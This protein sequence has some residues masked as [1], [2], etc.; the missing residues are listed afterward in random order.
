MSK[1]N[2]LIMI[3]LAVLVGF[4]AYPYF[5]PPTAPSAEIVKV[6]TSK[7]DHDKSLDDNSEAD[8]DIEDRTQSTEHNKPENSLSETDETQDSNTD[9]ASDESG[10]PNVPSAATSGNKKDFSSYKLHDEKKTYA[11]SESDPRIRYLNGKY[12]GAVHGYSVVLEINQAIS[13]LNFSSVVTYSSAK[14]D[15]IFNVNNNGNIILI[16]YGEAKFYLDLSSL[17]DL[18]INEGYSGYFQMQKVQ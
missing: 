9:P 14:T 13:S 1:F 11:I 16:Q 12:I 15:Y 7:I 5:H 4:F 17:P 18:K 3:S 2:T 6:T 10:N 8:A